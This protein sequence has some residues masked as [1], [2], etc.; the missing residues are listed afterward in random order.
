MLSHYANKRTGKTYVSSQTQNSITLKCIKCIPPESQNDN[1]GTVEWAVEERNFS[2]LHIEAHPENGSG[3]GRLLIHLAVIEAER[4]KCN[5]IK[6]ESAAPS[7]RGFY[8]NLGFRSDLAILNKIDEDLTKE[9][10][11]DKLKTLENPKI[12][13]AIRN[14][15][16]LIG[17]TEYVKGVSARMVHELWG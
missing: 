3:L 1:W 12:F 14:T 10:K 4:G 7:A 5:I 6:I 13:D 2:L 15:I 9:A 11:G 17:N 16:P 8:I